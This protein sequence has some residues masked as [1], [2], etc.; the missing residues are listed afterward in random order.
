VTDISHLAVSQ[1]YLEER[2]FIKYTDTTAASLLRMHPGDLA[3][4]FP[5]DGHMTTLQPPDGPGLV[6]KTVIKVPVL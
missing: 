5:T 4:F 2:D 3:V 1:A 6:R